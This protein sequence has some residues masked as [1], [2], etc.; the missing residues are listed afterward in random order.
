VAVVVIPVY[1]RADLLWNIV[2]HLDG[3]NLILIDDC[4]PDIQTRRAVE[5]IG[6]RA[7]NRFV[8]MEHNRGFPVAA[9]KGASMVRSDRFFLLNTDVVPLEG[10]DQN[11]WNAMD[12]HEDA[13]AVGAKL[14]FPDLVTVQHAGVD[15]D[16]RS[17]LPRHVYRYFTRQAMEVCEPRAYAMVTHAAVLFRTSAFMQAGGYDEAFGIGMYDDCDLGLKFREMG[18]IS[19]YE[20][21]AE[22]IHEESASFKT[23]PDLDEIYKHSEKLFRERWVLSGRI[24]PLLSVRRLED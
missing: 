1:G 10:W 6:S 20:P 24:F 14:L 11:M 12:R 19:V 8:S 2:R 9:N 4:S 16:K 18:F 23:R 3:H 7:G 5:E 22:L 13:A 17:G 15:L 21:T